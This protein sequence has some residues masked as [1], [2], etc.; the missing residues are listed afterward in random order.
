M[1]NLFHIQDYDIN[2]AKFNHWLHGDIVEEFTERFCRYTGF[3]YGC[4]VN[5]A[6]TA[7]M[8]LTRLYGKNHPFDIP[9]IIPPVVLNAIIE[10]GGSYKF[11][12]D[13]D[14]VGHRYTMYK[15]SMTIIDSA[16]EVEADLGIDMPESHIVIYSFYPTKPVGSCDGGMICSN[17]QGIIENL[18]ILSRNGLGQAR[19]SWEQCP[20]WIGWKF[21]MNSIQA[22][23][24]NENLKRLDDKKDKLAIVRA[25]YNNQFG[26]NNTS[27]HLY[28][29]RVENNERFIEHAK[30]AGI[31]CGI[32]YRAT[33]QYLIYKT[34]MSAMPKSEEEERHTISIPFHEK[35]TTDDMI[36]VIKCVKT[37][38]L[39]I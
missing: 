29:I 4:P 22:F 27:D 26:L 24:A 17:N 11:V 13:T 12:D 6:T 38:G 15:D 31:V 35:L 9:S 16:Q 32:H 34:D 21:Y 2:T 19:N 8:M 36:R 23:I 28:R 7:I 5:S 18:Q 3:K 10:G 25:V 37:S 39:L 20:M 33:H 1:I 14:W 30:R